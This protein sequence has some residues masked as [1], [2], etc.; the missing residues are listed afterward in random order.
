M[1]GMTDG[2][3]LGWQR[4]LGYESCNFPPTRGTEITSPSAFLNLRG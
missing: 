2:G 3:K 1:P 4:R